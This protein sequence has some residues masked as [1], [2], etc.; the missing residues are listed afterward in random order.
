VGLRP[1]Q[2]GFVGLAGKRALPDLG[3][4]DAEEPAAASVEGERVRLAEILLVIRRELTGGVQANLIQHPPEINQATNFIV[5]TAQAGDGIWHEQ[6]LAMGLQLTTFQKAMFGRRI[7][8]G[9][10]TAGR[11]GIHLF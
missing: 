11:C 7:A 2:D 1:V 6:I 9:R 4:G 8:R 3:I 10:S 5:A